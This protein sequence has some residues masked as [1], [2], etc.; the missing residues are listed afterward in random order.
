[1]DSRDEI[2]KNLMNI[3]APRIING[4]CKKDMNRAIR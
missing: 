2:I 4:E 1:M 3:V